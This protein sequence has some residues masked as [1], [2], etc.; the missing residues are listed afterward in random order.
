MSNVKSEIEKMLIEKFKF[1][2]G[3][4]ELAMVDPIAESIGHTNEPVG[5]VKKIFDKLLEVDGIPP[6]IS[7]GGLGRVCN[8]L[9]A[10]GYEHSKK[11]ILEAVEKAKE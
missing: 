8:Y 10:C 3:A 11:A 1:K 4:W 6:E 9:A 5:L 7:H 2:P